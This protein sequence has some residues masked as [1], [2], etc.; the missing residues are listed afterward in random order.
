MFTSAT[1]RSLVSCRTVDAR[2]LVLS[3]TLLLAACSPKF[4][5]REVRGSDA[6]YTVLMPAKPDTA[7]RD[8]NLGGVRTSMTMTGAEIDGITFAVGTATLPDA[9]QA[10]AV[11]P[12]MR[13]TLVGNI[14][15]T[16]RPSADER[17][18][19][20]PAGGGTAIEVQ[21]SGNA[22]GQQRVLHARFIARDARV[23]QAIVTGPEQAVTAEIV[24]TFMT[25]FKVK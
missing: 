23:F 11:L 5:W 18:P 10:L 16:A 9:Q 13:D 4:D 8:I 21:A 20:Q 19:A 25:S 1:V 2:V 17:P 12:V 22:G 24:E 15:G 6:L 3:C 7:T 14:N